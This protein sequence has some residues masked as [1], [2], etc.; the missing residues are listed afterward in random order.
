MKSRWN[1]NSIDL[2]ECFNATNC[3]KKIFTIS[4]LLKEFTRNFWIDGLFF[5][6]I[7]KLV[8]ELF[9][10]FYLSGFCFTW[11]PIFADPNFAILGSIEHDHLGRNVEKSKAVAESFKTNHGFFEYVNCLKKGQFFQIIKFFN[12][13]FELNKNFKETRCK[14][15]FLF[16]KSKRFDFEDGKISILPPLKDLFVFLEVIKT[17]C[18]D[19]GRILVNLRVFIGKWNW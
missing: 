17:Y 3:L 2:G 7:A 10:R 11:I 5:H 8:N 18:N 19:L 16:Q 14:L 13:T 6:N 4:D 12:L 15:I 1:F 9:F